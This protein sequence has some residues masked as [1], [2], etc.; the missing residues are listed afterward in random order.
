MH[1]ALRASAIAACTLAAMAATP[2]DATAGR[3]VP[4]NVKARAAM[5][6]DLGT[7]AAAAYRN[8][9]AEAVR[10]AIG[11]IAG[12]FDPL[13]HEDLVPRADEFIP[14]GGIRGKRDLGTG[15]CEVSAGLQIDR[16]LLED[17]LRQERGG[18]RAIATVVRFRIEGKYV[19]SSGISP[20][21]PTVALNTAMNRAGCR[22]FALE[23]HHD[24]FASRLRPLNQRIVDDSGVEETVYGSISFAEALFQL[25]REVRMNLLDEGSDSKKVSDFNILVIGDV[26]VIHEGDD[27]LGSGRIARAEAEVRLRAINGDITAPVFP[28]SVRITAPTDEEAVRIAAQQAMELIT[29]DIE[30]SLSLCGGR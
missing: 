14:R 23:E 24:R 4:Y 5:A 8:A 12:S 10:L 6:G 26:N 9:R 18:T 21:M 28:V 13:R 30:R 29:K 27:P 1:T 15:F 17:A 16:A 19:G 25:I 7:C 11:D 20:L 3:Q 22:T 2:D